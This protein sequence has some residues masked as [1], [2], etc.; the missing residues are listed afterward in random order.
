MLNK[1]KITFYD[2]ALAQEQWFES[3]NR[4]LHEGFGSESTELTS[5]TLESTS[6]EHS[7]IE[8]TLKRRKQSIKRDNFKLCLPVLQWGLI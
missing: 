8:R 3:T 1:K 2:A 4:D 7:L 6:T 5:S